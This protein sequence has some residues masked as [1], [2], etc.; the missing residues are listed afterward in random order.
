MCEVMGE[1]RESGENPLAWSLESF[2][3]LMIWTGFTHQMLL[4][5]L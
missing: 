2:L 5:Q 4:G 3:C 1:L